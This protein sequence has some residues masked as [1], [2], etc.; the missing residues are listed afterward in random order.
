MSIIQ[1]YDARVERVENGYIVYL[2]GDDPNSGA[3][4]ICEDDDN[5]PLKSI[6]SVLWEVIEHFAAGGS[7]Y[8]KE[9]IVVRREPG[10]KWSDGKD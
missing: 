8:D 9:R 5:D 4:S 3:V 7:R 1:T 10:D 2:S 6:E